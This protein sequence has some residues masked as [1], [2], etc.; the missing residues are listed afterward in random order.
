MRILCLLWKDKPIARC[1]WRYIRH[2][3]DVP[4]FDLLRFRRGYIWRLS[5][6][7]MLVDALAA[8][9]QFKR[10]NPISSYLN[11]HSGLDLEH[12]AFLGFFAKGLLHRLWAAYV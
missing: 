7:R 12:G 9:F 2:A 1:A 8:L 11:V 5:T 6:S 3:T 4:E 10:G